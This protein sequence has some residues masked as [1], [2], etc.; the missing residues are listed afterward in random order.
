MVPVIAL[1]FIGLI[2][3]TI[4]YFSYYVVI[5]RFK[6]SGLQRRF[7]LF[8][9]VQL[10]AMSL[11]LLIS[12]GYGGWTLFLTVS[13]IAIPFSFLIALG[14]WFRETP[15][16]KQSLHRRRVATHTHEQKDNTEAESYDEKR[17]MI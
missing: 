16:M 6:L 2:V 10:S 5:S 15:T 14:T 12:I 17:T 8:V 4:V 1:I 7:L 3:S 9:C 11:I 13:L